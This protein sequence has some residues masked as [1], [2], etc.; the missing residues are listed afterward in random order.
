M[1]KRILAAILTLAIVISLV[2]SALAKTIPAGQ[3]VDNVLFY[4]NCPSPRGLIPI[5]A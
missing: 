2:P 4:V 5:M 3:H 1:K